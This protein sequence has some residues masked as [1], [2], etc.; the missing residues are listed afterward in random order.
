[1]SNIFHIGYMRTGSTWLQAEVFPKLPLL[2]GNSNPICSDIFYKNILQKSFFEYNSKD[3]KSAL[4]TITERQPNIPFLFSEETLSGNLLEPHAAT[5]R[6]MLERL[7][8]LSD[9]DTKIII[10]LRN[11]PSLIW[12]LYTQYLKIGG[13]GTLTDFLYREKSNCYL[14]YLYY[15]S[16]VEYCYKLF[17][18]ENVYVGHFENLVKSPVN[19]VEDI[20]S[21]IF[22]K[23]ISPIEVNLAPQSVG[24]SIEIHEFLRWLNKQSETRINPSGGNFYKKDIYEVV[25]NAITDFS[26]AT[27]ATKIIPKELSTMLDTYCK[28]YENDSRHTI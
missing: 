13:C 15:G 3:T 10:I 6:E 21:F 14:S 20:I 9:Q 12:S 7:R 2:Y 27:H 24:Y 23:P 19:F 25:R 1:M 5:P 16:F 17:K 8:D 22:G 4:N 11:Q 26:V 18:K 28:R